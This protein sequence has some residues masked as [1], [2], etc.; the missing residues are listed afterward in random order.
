[1]GSVYS[2]SGVSNIEADR[3]L[4]RWATLDDAATFGGSEGCFQRASLLSDRGA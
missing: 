2:F 3:S 4:C 1:M